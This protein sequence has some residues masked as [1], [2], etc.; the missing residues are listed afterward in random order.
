LDRNLFLNLAKY[1]LDKKSENI[2]S[3]LSLNIVAC[4]ILMIGLLF[5]SNQNE[6]KYVKPKLRVVK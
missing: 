2:L 4:F 1:I 5:K 3:T 6:T